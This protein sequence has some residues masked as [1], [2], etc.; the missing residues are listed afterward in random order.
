MLLLLFSRTRCYVALLMT[1]VERFA[2]R[3]FPI[4]RSLRE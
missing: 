2:C 1:P 3:A 4:L